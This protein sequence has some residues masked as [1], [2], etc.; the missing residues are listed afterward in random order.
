MVVLHPNSRV[1]TCM[2][3]DIVRFQWTGLPM[4]TVIAS[5]I[6]QRKLNEVYANLPGVTGI[7]D[8]MVIYGTSTEEHDRNFLRFPKATRKHNLNLNKDKCQFCKETAHYF[9]H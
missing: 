7:A 8:D 6:C 9:G 2:A 1:L 3:L 5:D 4:G